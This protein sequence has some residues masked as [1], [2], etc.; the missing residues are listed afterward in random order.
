M[1]N[2]DNDR[3]SDTSQQNLNK[4]FNS[5]QCP[6]HGI[7]IFRGEECPKCREERERQQKEK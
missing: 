3:T 7:R 4:S 6:K 1:P 2:N 5:Y